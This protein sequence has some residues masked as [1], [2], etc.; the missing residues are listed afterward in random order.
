M[1][2][3][4]ENP[5]PLRACAYVLWGEIAN[6]SVIKYGMSLCVLW[7]TTK[8]KMGLD[9]LGEV[10]KLVSESI[11][12]DKIVFERSAEVGEGA[13]YAGIQRKRI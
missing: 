9:V 6:R 10:S 8:Q 4:D 13:S 7:R 1:N 2:K 12:I 11:V 5:F 3:T